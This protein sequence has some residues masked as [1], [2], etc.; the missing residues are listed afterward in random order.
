MLEVA[1]I[2]SKDFPYC[3]VDL[4]EVEGKVLFGELTFTPQANVMDY[5]T[6]DTLK[7]MLCFYND[8]QNK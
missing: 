6:E 5:Y 4:Y 8:T 1:Q 7:D 2:L 3:R